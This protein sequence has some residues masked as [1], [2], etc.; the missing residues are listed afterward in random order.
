[1]H[2]QIEKNNDNA[3]DRNLL[4]IGIFLYG[5]HDW[6]FSGNSEFSYEIFIV[7]SRKKTL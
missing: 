4:M 3:G 1:M 5:D 7:R 2:I 6:E